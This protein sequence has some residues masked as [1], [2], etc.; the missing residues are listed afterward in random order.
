MLDDC[1]K[2]DSFAV[3]AFV[4][5]KFLAIFILSMD[6]RFSFDSCSILINGLFDV[7]FSCS[8]SDRA[9]TITGLI[10]CSTF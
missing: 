4:S 6:I 5:F 8:Q 10:I 9:S 2:K 7:E 1:D 3:N